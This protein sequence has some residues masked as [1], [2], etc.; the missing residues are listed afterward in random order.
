VVPAFKRSFGVGQM[1][2]TFRDVAHL[3]LAFSH[4]EER[5]AGRDDLRPHAE[6]PPLV[7][8]PTT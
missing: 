4:F 8:K 7:K 1:S 3:P 5:I 6:L 2:A